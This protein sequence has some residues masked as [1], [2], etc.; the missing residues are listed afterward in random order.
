M[1]SP[2][3]L[4]RSVSESFLWCTSF[5]TVPPVRGVDVG[6][7]HGTSLASAKRDASMQA[8]EYLKS[9]GNGAN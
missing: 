1:V 3:M 5:F 4:Q 8:L 9:H 2:I 7:G 6:I